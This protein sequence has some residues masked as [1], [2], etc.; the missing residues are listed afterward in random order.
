M[1]ELDVIGMAITTLDKIG[2]TGPIDRDINGMNA[3]GTIRGPFDVVP[4]GIDAVPTYPVL[5]S[6]DADRERTMCF[7]GDREGIP[8]RAPEGKEDLLAAKVENVW[9][10]A[11]HCH[12]NLNFQFNSQSTS[13]QFTSRTTI[14][15]RAWQSIKLSSDQQEK[16]LVAWA[17]TSLGMLLRWWHS[18]KQQGGRGNI[19]KTAMQSMPLLDVTTLQPNQLVNAVRLFDEMCDKP[20]LPLHEI[21]K[22]TVRHELDERFGLEVLDLH[23]SL[24]VAG[25]PLEI[26]RLKLAQEPSI[27]GNK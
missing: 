7:S 11:T 8:R 4:V 21:D 5:W 2:E 17:N 18:N 10:T 23:P 3:N 20:M 9:A 26:L 27:R 13:M 22:D 1:A 12:F 25:G 16:A 24:F 15:G 19:G 6:H 14:G